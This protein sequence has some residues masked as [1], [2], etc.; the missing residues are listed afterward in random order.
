MK[1]LILP[2]FVPLSLPA[3][4]PPSLPPSLLPSSFLPSLPPSLP[5]ADS[6]FR[7]SGAVSGVLI[8]CVVSAF[9]GLVRAAY[10]DKN[11]YFASLASNEL[12]SAQQAM[13][14]IHHTNE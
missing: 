7:G 11:E 3:S 10:E 8:F 1:L 12:K 14:S 2:F 4:L 5:K 6:Y 13:D 9:L